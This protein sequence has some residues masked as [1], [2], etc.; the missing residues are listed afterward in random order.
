ML[1]RLVVLALLLAAP[2][3]QAAEPVFPPGSRIGLAPPEEMQP[4]RRFIGF[5]NTAKAATITLIEM[6]A[7]AYGTVT[8]DLTKEA[9]KAQGMTVTTRETFKLGDREAL[10]VG[11]EQA[12]GA[13]KIRKWLLVTSDPTLTALVVAD[14]GTRQGYSDEAM[15]R[16]LTSVA[17]R[18]P[19]P[20]EDQMKALPFRLG[21]RSGFRPVRVAGGNMLTLTEGPQD[22]W[23]DVSQPIVMVGAS[24]GPTPAAGEPRERFAR[25]ALALNQNL[26]ELAFERSQSFRL[27]GVEWHELVARAVHGPT[28][29]PVVVMQTL[30]FDGGRTIRMVGMAPAKARDDLLPRFRA[31]IDSVEP[32]G[33]S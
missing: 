24:A 16:A 10:L 14:A 13:T 19:L 26:R 20:V 12:A 11:G 3:A 27:K 9:L 18:A 23:K 1:R 7:E 25:A 8:A 33:G 32:G 15:R 2:A 30:R 31:L 28:G 21:E 5:E 22:S 29:E 17:L 6:P 4:S